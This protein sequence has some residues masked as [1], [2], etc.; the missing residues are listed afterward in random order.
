[1]NV[2]DYR[3]FLSERETLKKLISQTSPGNVIGRLSL[4]SRL[5][6]VNEE[7]GVYEGYMRGTLR[8]WLM[9]A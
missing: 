4:E 2:H 9:P 7:L 1:M 5:R 6:Q 3:F 8:A